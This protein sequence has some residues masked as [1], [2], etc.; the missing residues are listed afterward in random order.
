[1]SENTES[2]ILDML[3]RLYETQSNGH[4]KPSEGTLLKFAE[5]DKTV[6]LMKQNQDNFFLKADKFMESTEKN[7]SKKWVETGLLW[8]L[9]LS[10]SVIVVTLTIFI[11]KGIAEN[12]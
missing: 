6:S 10:G 4:D 2:K 8:F 9:G 1:M 11:F 5:V 7:F 12:L 3:K